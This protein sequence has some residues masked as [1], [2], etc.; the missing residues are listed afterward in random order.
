MNK[1]TFASIALAAS[2][3]TAPIALAD[4]FGYKT[5]DLGSTANSSL[6]NR[7]KA[8]FSMGAGLP[9]SLELRSGGRNATGPLIPD[10]FN[11]GSDANILEVSKDSEPMLDN[12]LSPGD[13]GEGIHGTSGVLVDVGGHRLN[14]FAGSKEAN[15]SK[16]PRDRYFYFGDNGNSRIASEV[17]NRNA[18]QFGESA[19][20][21]EAP[22]PGSLFLLGTG[23]LCLAL[24]LFWR[25]AKRQTA[26]S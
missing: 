18:G 3:A 19:T 25:A 20:L 22:E 15:G 2:I 21:S 14:L 9:G 8:D 6:N 12:L 11:S 24:M 17:P 1:R 10:A 23:L 4:S 7:G 26:G 16:S 13:S 5:S